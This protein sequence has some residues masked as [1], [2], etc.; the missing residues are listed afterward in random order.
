VRE[1]YTL[2]VVPLIDTYISRDKVLGGDL[3]GAIGLSRTVVDEL[4]AEG[5]SIW[6]PP[7]A[8]ARPWL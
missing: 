5:G 7:A 6:N 2:T 3:D 8:D 1:R 4:F